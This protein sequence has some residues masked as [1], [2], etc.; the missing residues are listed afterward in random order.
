MAA[1]SRDLQRPLGAFL[2]LDIAQ[3]EQL[4]FAFMHFRLRPR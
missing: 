4:D 1:G 2:A 3:V